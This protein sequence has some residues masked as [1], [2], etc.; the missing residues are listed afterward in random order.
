MRVGVSSGGGLIIRP[1]LHGASGMGSSINYER[2]M[3]R[4]EFWIEMGGIA[5]GPLIQRRI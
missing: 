1:T 3:R 2:P 5:K 4:C